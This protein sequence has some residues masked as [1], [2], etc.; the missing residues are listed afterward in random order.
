MGRGSLGETAGKCEERQ[1]GGGCPRG[2][3]VRIT[4]ISLEWLSRDAIRTT[5][6]AATP[7]RLW[8]LGGL[9]PGWLVPRDPGL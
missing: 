3:L 7:L 1:E 5:D 4:M 6:M 9:H 8:M 2:L